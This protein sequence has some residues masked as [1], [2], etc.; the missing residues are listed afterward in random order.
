MP[1]I[2]IHIWSV[3]ENLDT[4]AQSLLN[5]VLKIKH[6]MLSLVLII[7]LSEII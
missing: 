7:H 2:S 4:Q 1:Q 3:S 6:E 5:L